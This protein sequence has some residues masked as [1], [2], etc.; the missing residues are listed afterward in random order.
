MSGPLGSYRGP[1][2]E[3]IPPQFV[4]TRLLRLVGITNWLELI[5]FTCFLLLFSYYGVV[6]A[7]GEME[8]EFRACREAM[9]DP[10][11]HRCPVTGGRLLVTPKLV[12]CP[13]HQQEIPRGE[14]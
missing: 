13:D 10:R 8:A 6:L 11:T 4:L 5:L 7:H 12:R 14:D 9:A 2:S 3:A 1:R